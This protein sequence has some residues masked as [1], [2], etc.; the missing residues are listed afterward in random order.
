MKQT[1]L[2]QCAACVLREHDAYI[3]A[4]WR[5]AY[6]LNELKKAIPI[7]RRWAAVNMR[8]PYY[9]A[10]YGHGEY[11]RIVPADETLDGMRKETEG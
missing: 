4:R 9:H 3:C 5:L 2:K 10:Q 1:E 11:F 6:A 8:C 7:V